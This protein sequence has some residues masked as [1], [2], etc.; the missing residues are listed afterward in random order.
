MTANIFH[1]TCWKG[2]VLWRTKSLAWLQ[3]GAAPNSCLQT[4]H[5]PFE[6]LPEQDR[7][8]FI[9]VQEAAAYMISHVRCTRTRQWIFSFL[10]NSATLKKTRASKFFA[11]NCIRGRTVINKVTHQGKAASVRSFPS[12]LRGLIKLE[13]T[14]RGNFPTAG[15]LCAFKNITSESQ[16]WQNYPFLIFPVQRI[17]TG[18]TFGYWLQYRKHFYQV[19]PFAPE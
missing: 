9:N 8:E 7:C 1:S 14:R 15:F 10:I 3:S 6:Q 11:N 17:W 18:P 19:L 4:L 13:N 16:E 5:L 12:L 2:R